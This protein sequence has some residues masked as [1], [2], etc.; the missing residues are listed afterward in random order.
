MLTVV[1]SLPLFFSNVIKPAERDIAELAIRAGFGGKVLLRA[2]PSNFVMIS[3]K[4][5]HVKF[6]LN[7]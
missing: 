4:G 6:R 2:R 1:N 3:E 5:P 7:W